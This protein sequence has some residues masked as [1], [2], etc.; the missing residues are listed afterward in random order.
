M[1]HICAFRLESPVRF[2]QGW[3]LDRAAARSVWLS[4]VLYVPIS[5]LFLFI[6]TALFSYY[7]HPTRSDMLGKITAEG[8]SDLQN[9]GITPEHPEY[10]QKLN[11]QVG[12]KV[13]PP[14]YGVAER[15]ET[16]YATE[17]RRV[18]GQ[19]VPS[20][21]LDSVA[22]QANRFEL[23]LLDA[24]RRGEVAVPLVS[25]D[26]R[27]TAVADLDRLSSLE[28]PHRIFDARCPVTVSAIS[29]NEAAL[30]FIPGEPFTRYGEAIKVAAGTGT[31]LVAATCGEE[32]FYIPT[33]EAIA[34]GGYETSYIASQD[35]GG[36]LVDKANRLLGAVAASGG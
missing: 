34:V 27:E 15:E 19:T 12:D 32:P 30:A 22:S 6:G 4:V 13:F 14:T 21:V 31:T 1:P 10:E 8:A 7:Q 23:A 2:P 3:K 26:F 9:E 16:K 17:H 28:A 29:I 35:T 36:A 25:V 24:V 5:A 11:E 33:R 18:D 20:V